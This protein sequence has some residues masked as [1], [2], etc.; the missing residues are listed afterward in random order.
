M[1]ELS[2]LPTD[3][4]SSS[5]SAAG[6]TELPQALSTPGK[7]IIGAVVI[8]LLALVAYW[9]LHTAGYIWDDGGW[10]VHNHFVHHWR[11]LWNIWFNPHDSIQYYP[12]VFTAFNLQWHIWGGNALG[13]HVL[14][15]I[16][17][18]VPAHA[19][20]ACRQRRRAGE[21]RLHA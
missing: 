13:Y 21:S 2:S 9:P 3:P 6:A 10:L 14:N 11:G 8:V 1:S 16:M 18:A 5:D 17:Q 15:I 4:E 20:R 19:R 7:R 12:M